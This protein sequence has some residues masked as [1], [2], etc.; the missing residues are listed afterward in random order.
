VAVRRILREA[1]AALRRTKRVKPAAPDTCRI[2]PKRKVEHWDRC[3]SSL[4]SARRR[5][6]RAEQAEISGGFPKQQRDAS[7]GASILDEDKGPGKPGPLSSAELIPI[8]SS[9]FFFLL[10]SSLRGRR[11]PAPPRPYGMATGRS[12]APRGR[13]SGYPGLRRASS[14]GVAARAIPV[15]QQERS[16]PATRSLDWSGN[17]PAWASMV[18][19]SSRGRQCA[20]SR[21]ARQAAI[22]PLPGAC[23]QGEG[24]STAR[25]SKVAGRLAGIA[26]GADI[27]ARERMGGRGSGCGLRRLSCWYLS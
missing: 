3:S 5:R 17:Q 11:S 27:A 26:T 2:A 18:T 13:I 9:A 14:T 16:K 20:A 25:W 24:I 4:P 22:G 10:R 8:C 1:L 23:R 21:M 7:T 15:R 19:S 6:A 12:G